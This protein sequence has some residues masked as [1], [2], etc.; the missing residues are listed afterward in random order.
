[1]FHVKHPHLYAVVLSD[2]DPEDKECSI[3]HLTYDLDH[4]NEIASKSPKWR[5]VVR[6]GEFLNA[7]D[8]CST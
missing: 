8:Q 3:L 2:P 1:M 7:D 4:A 6:I 5:H